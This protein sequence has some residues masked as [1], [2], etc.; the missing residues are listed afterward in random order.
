M[1]EEG[2]MPSSDV[3]PGRSSNGAGG[4]PVLSAEMGVGRIAACLDGS[5]VGECILPHALAVARALGAPLILLRV[6]EG[7]TTGEAPPDPLS[8][9]IRRR[10]T[11]DYLERLA[12]RGTA[13]DSVEAEVIEGQ[14]A[15]EICLWARRHG[16][17]LT[18]LCSHGTS[19]ETKWS[20]ASTARKLVEGAPGSLLLVPAT[21]RAEEGVARYRRL[22]VPVDGSPRG[23]SV[24]PLARRIAEAQGAELILAHVVPVPDLTEIGPLDAADLDLRERLT[25]RN[26]RV[27][28]DYLDRLRA[29]LSDSDAP[30]RALVLG[31]ADAR[32]RLARLIAEENV[33]LVVLSAHGRAARADVPLG[34]VTAYLV[35]HAEVPLLILRHPAVASMRRVDQVDREDVRHPSQATL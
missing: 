21:A 7:R 33:E 25:R 13:E 16:V 22:L 9:D 5:E 30:V 19:G 24:L 11:Q 20:L 4:A 26:E 1:T 3:A 10:E 31:A 35:E 27:A 6:L 15:E 34:G 32:G 14:A 17:V 23:E 2:A 18:V 8:W 28:H 29:Q 12:E